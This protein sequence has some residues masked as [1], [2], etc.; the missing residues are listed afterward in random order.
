[1]QIGVFAKTFPGRTAQE[2]LAASRAAGF[3]T[4]QFNMACLGLP[5]MPDAVSA[6][7]VA[8]VAAAGAATGVTLA[9]LSATYNMIHPDPAVRASG[10]KRLEVLAA[11]A[12]PWARAS[13]RSAPAR[14]IR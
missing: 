11:A 8:S 4:V 13:S 12:R 2:A 3:A 1:M 7:D 5:A 6:E 14:A 10:L 9:G